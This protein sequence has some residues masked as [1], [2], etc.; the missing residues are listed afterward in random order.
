VGR[1]ASGTL[2]PQ[3]LLGPASTSAATPRGSATPWWEP[4]GIDGHETVG[5]EFLVD[6]EVESTGHPN[7][8]SP[9]C[10]IPVADDLGAESVAKLSM[11][12]VAT[13]SPSPL[14]EAF[15]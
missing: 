5:A 3:R 7:E 13:V 4:E 2:S 9:G 6:A 10:H 8:A 15:L 1:N 14:L 12:N 11:G